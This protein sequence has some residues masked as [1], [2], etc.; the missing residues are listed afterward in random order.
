MK[1]RGLRFIVFEAPEKTPFQSVL[2]TDYGYYA[3]L[4]KGRVDIEVVY[5][6]ERR[7]DVLEKAI[8]KSKCREAYGEVVIGVDPGGNPRYVAIGDDELLDYGRVS[9]EQLYN[10]IER[11]ITCYPSTRII[12]RVG[13]GADGWATALNVKNRFNVKV[14][15]VDEEGTTSSISGFDRVLLIDKFFSSREIRFDKDL[16]SA[17]KIALRKGVDA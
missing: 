8:L 13:G 12:V 5:D 15:V 3:S 7:C 9:V 10:V 2:Y 17:L 11:A 1:K 4:I 6:P 16:F 14:E